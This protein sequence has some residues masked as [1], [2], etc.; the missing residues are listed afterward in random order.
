[1]IFENEDIIDH[2]CNSLFQFSN[3]FQIGEIEVFHIFY[4]KIPYSI[5]SDENKQI[6]VHLIQNNIY[7]IRNN[8]YTQI[9]LTSCAQS[10]IPELKLIFDSL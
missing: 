3:F 8:Y 6:F 5:I 2:A 4:L 10:S 9:F 1:L 7:E